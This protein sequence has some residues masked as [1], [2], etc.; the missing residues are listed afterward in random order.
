M[1]LIVHHRDLV[2]QDPFADPV[3]GATHIAQHPYLK[4]HIYIYFRDM[5]DREMALREL[6]RDPSTA[7]LSN[8]PVT[9]AQY[10]QRAPFC[11]MYHL[12]R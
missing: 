1:R 4:D 7:Q 11:E 2:L 3:T 10:I 5:D 12:R 6:Q 9:S 8:L